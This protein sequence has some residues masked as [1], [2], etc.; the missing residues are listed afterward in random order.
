[1]SVACSAQAI[2]DEKCDELGNQTAQIDA[3][4]HVTRFEYDSRG[5]RTKRILPE[6]QIET[7]A[8]DGAAGVGPQVC[9]EHQRVTMRNWAKRGVRAIF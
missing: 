3:N 2:K 4:G 7:N 5:R 9:L 1:M 8:Y 6:G